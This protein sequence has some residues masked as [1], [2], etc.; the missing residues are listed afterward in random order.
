MEGL[1]QPPPM[2]VLE[3]VKCLWFH[4]SYLKD[5]FRAGQMVALYGKLEASRSGNALNAPPGFTKFKLIQPTFEILPDA[6]ATGEDAEF[7]M[8]EM[9]RI[10]PVYESLGGKTPWGAKL[11]SR[12]LRRVMWTVFRELRSLEQRPKRRCRRAARAARAAWAHGRAARPALPCRRN[13]DDRADE[14]HEPQ[15]T[16]G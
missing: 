16:G 7:T 8:L 13:C 9:G 10:V 14:L 5:K 15:R 11:T 4:G 12:W 6:A 2:A 1:L 3:T